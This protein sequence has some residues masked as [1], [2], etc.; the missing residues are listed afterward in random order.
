MARNVEIKALLRDR[1]G[2]EAWAT[3]RANSG[4]QVIEQE[5]VF[6]R[7]D[8]ARL[9]LRILG[10]SRGELIRYERSN[11]AEVRLSQYEPRP[12]GPFSP[13]L[14]GRLVW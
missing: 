14:W 1:A 3:W 9:K 12:C 8:G 2:A 10:P 7:C 4:P 6:F 13:K 11:S 5:D